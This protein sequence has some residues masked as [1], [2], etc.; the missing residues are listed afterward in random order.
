MPKKCK[1]HKNGEC[2]ADRLWDQGVATGSE[3]KKKK[4]LSFSV[5][6][7]RTRWWL[8]TS[9]NQLQ[10]EPVKARVLLASAAGLGRYRG[11]VWD[12]NRDRALEVCSIWD[13][14]RG[15]VVGQV[16]KL[17]AVTHLLVRSPGKCS[18]V[19]PGHSLTRSCKPV[20]AARLEPRCSFP[21][22]QSQ[23]FPHG[24]CC[25]HWVEQGIQKT[26]LARLCNGQGRTGEKKNLPLLKCSI[27]CFP[28]GFFFHSTV[29]FW[30]YNLKIPLPHS[31]LKHRCLQKH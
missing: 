8:G 11:S 29:P 18:A 19:L 13:F 3:T 28:E 21:L 24:L 15:S 1:T 4:Y 5:P 27:C 17:K 7:L 20:R 16:Q 14:S 2:G 23:P 6:P 30:C 25:L 9:G 12:K 26:Y 10:G 31:R 22:G